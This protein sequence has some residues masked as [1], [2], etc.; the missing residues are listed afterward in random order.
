MVSGCAL[1]D[2]Y[3]DYFDDLSP[4]QT[5]ESPVATSDST[6]NC[7]LKN[8]PTGCVGVVSPAPALTR[9]EE[10]AEQRRQLAEMMP[11][12]PR[13]AAPA[14][15]P[16]ASFPEP[17]APQTTIAAAEDFSRHGCVWQGRIYQPGD[18]IR[19]QSHGEILASELMIYGDSFE[20]LSGV[21]GPVQGC[22]CSSSSGHWGCV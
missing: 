18:S 6:L 22:D 8:G 3:Q 15:P 16:A 17:A 7:E 5:A 13:P 19:A 2:S 10:K 12:A 21:S 4:D 14:E 11:E 9:E 20:S 1:Y